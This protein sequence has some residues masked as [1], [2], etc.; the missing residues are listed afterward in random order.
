MVFTVVSRGVQLSKNVPTY[1]FVSTSVSGCLEVS[2]EVQRY[3]EV[4]SCA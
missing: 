3:L 4:F 1:L 2:R